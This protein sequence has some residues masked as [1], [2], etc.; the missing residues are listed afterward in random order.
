MGW[1]EARGL[2]VGT[3]EPTNFDWENENNTRQ[4][5]NCVE[6]VKPGLALEK[7]FEKQLAEIDAGIHDKDAE[8]MKVVGAEPKGMES[9]LGQDSLLK[10]THVNGLSSEVSN[11]PTQQALMG[12]P[13]AH[14]PNKLLDREFISK[15]A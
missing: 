1:Q 10:H 6:Q 4:L 15:Q 7:D 9:S 11:G 2:Q 14:G 5:E 3:S 8:L 12:S 13:E